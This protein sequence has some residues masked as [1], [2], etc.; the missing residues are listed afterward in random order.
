VGSSKAYTVIRWQVGLLKVSL[1][2]STWH[3]LFVR[4]HTPRRSPV[5]DNAAGRGEI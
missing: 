2:G 3:E 5:V 1:I 4:P